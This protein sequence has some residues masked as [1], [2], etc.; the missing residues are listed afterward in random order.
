MVKI[1][2]FIV[3]SL[4]NPERG[5]NKYGESRVKRECEHLHNEPPRPARAEIVRLHNEKAVKSCDENC[6]AVSKPWPE[7]SV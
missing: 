6:G 2:V 5:R 4:G 3:R 7:N 1:T